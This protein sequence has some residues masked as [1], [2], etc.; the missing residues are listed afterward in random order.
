MKRIIII[1][2][3]LM[4]S[5]GL[6]SCHSEWENPNRLTA[7]V[8]FTIYPNSIREY[9]LNNPGGFKYYSSDP[10]SNS[11]GILVYRVDMTEF[12][13][14]DRLPPNS[15]NTCCN[16][17]GEC[18]RLVADGLFVLDNCNNITYNILDGT[19]FEGEGRYRLYPYT[20]MFDGTALR[21]TSY[22]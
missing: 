10:E 21:I 17:E 6:P 20:Y 7:I 8:D 1:V 15:P 16:D 12:R 18:S 14:W 2:V 13:V 19:V 11:R 22:Y 5:A 9:E 4:V 3:L